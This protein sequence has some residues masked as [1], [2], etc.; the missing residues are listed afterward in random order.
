M[1]HFIAS[2]DSTAYIFIFVRIGFEPCN[3]LH[4]VAFVLPG[5]AF[6]FC[7]KMMCFLSWLRICLLIPSLAL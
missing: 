7:G 1:A 3:N 5:P 2:G 4:L 6:C